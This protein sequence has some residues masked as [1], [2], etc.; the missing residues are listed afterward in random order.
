MNNEKLDKAITQFRR[1]RRMRPWIAVLGVLQ[2]ALAGVLVRAFFL[3][4]RNLTEFV[5][6]NEALPSEV[7]HHQLSATVVLIGL[8]VGFSA[9]GVIGLHSIFEGITENP[10]DTLLNH[11]LEDKIKQ[12]DLSQEDK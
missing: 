10:R 7:F 6:P 9:L 3:S 1:S 8:A 4:I 2:L 11:L 5:F 12:T